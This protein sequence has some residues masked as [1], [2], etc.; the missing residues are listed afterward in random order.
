MDR[1]AVWVERVSRVG[2]SPSST[3]IKQITT[4]WVPISR[5]INKEVAEDGPF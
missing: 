5:S 1:V 2:P 4:F 3:I